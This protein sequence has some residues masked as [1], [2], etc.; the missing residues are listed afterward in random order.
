M[1]LKTY[2]DHQ[3]R[4]KKFIH[5]MLIPKEQ[6]RPR[7]WV[8]VFLNPFLH[9]KGK[10]ALI[11]RR[12]RMD[13]LPFN[14]FSMGY[15]SIIEDFSVIN[16]G[17]GA[18]KIG[19][20]V[21]IGIGNVLIGPLEIGNNVIFAQNVVVSGFNH[22]YQ[23]INIPILDQKIYSTASISI[24]DDCWIGAN[25]VI[26]AGVQIGKHAVIAAGSIVTKNVEAYTV[27]GGNP[28]KILKRYDSEINQWVKP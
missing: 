28:A 23:D 8:R 25:A 1:D 11:R 22:A 10:G 9:K 6:A 2:V 20:R 15:F 14:H 27:V 21:K 13:V 16:N 4:L 17:I 5:R 3:P 24:A 7:W 26:T 19:N 18:V 12:V